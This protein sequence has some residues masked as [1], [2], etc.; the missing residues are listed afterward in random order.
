MC[1]SPDPIIPPVN[2]EEVLHLV[3]NKTPP[4]CRKI[5]SKLIFE[6]LRR[7]KME[8]KLSV[9]LSMSFSPFILSR[10]SLSLS[11]SHSFFLSL[12][13]SL[14]FFLSS[15]SLYIFIHRGRTHKEMYSYGPP[16][17]GRAKAGR[18]ARTYIQRLCEDTG[19]CPEDLH[20]AMND[21]EEWRERS[22]I[23]VLPARHDDDDDNFKQF[24]LA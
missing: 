10:L 22:G 24:I 16:T 5:L 19:C 2:V 15:L 3:R 18:P 8:I 4:N 9:C 7:K 20:R 21:R 1:L 23:S 17:H 12:S 13:L 6:E 14:S 11:L